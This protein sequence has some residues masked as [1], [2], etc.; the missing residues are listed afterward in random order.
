MLAGVRLAAA[1]PVIQTTAA[2]LGKGRPKRPLNIKILGLL[3]G[4]GLFSTVLLHR[5]VFAFYII[6]GSSMSPTLNDGDAALVN[7]LAARVGWIDRGEIVLVRDGHF[8]EYAT[9]RV[10]G[11]PGELIEIRDDHVYV[12]GRLLEE[13]YLPRNTITTSKCP[14]WRLGPQQYFVLGDNR[15]VSYDSRCYGPVGRDAIM[16]SYTRTFWACR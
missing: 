13:A 7:M 15:P 8:Q 1:D 10:I 6:E 16:G 3:V 12:S 9:K 11:L 5:Y 4:C 2:L 14:G